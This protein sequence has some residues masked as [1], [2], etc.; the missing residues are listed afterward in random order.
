MGT[1]WLLPKC[2]Q[3]KNPKKET[4]ENIVYKFELKAKTSHAKGTLLMFL[5]LA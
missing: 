3:I 5:F 2:K 1:L 4:T